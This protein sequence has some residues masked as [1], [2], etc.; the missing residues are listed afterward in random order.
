MRFLK[1]MSAKLMVD[2]PASMPI[3]KRNMLATECSN[4]MATK[5]EMGNLEGIA[6]NGG[7]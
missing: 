6:G 5:V 3:G 1:M 7:D 4:P 2:L